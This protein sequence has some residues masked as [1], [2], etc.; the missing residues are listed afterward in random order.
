MWEQFI[1]PDVESK[2]EELQR[3]NYERTSMANA[4]QRANDMGLASGKETQ[5]PPNASQ[6]KVQARLV[7]NFDELPDLIVEGDSHGR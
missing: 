4:R 6:S 2:K 3:K 1:T 7:V 5:A